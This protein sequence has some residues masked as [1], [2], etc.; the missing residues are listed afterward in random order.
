LMDFHESNHREFSQAAL[1]A[2]TC[3]FC[4][5]YLWRS[6]QESILADL[7]LSNYWFIIHI[8]PNFLHFSYSNCR[9]LSRLYWIVLP[10]PLSWRQSSNEDRK[11]HKDSYYDFLP[12]VAYTAWPL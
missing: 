7:C 8:K 9:E 3:T 5:E 2:N 11:R 1:D 4:P 12:L 6:R 10:G